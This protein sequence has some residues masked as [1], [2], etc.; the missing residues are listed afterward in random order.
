[1][2]KIKRINQIKLMGKTIIYKLT[3]NMKAH[4]NVIF[5]ADWQIPALY[6]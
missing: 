4:K 1:M 5:N 6:Q 2:S 3:I